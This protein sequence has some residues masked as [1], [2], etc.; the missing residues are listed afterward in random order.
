MLLRRSTPKAG[1]TK[2]SEEE[3]QQ[4]PHK[5]RIILRNAKS[6]AEYKEDLKQEAAESVSD[7]LLMA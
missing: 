5:V 3:E 2:G 4:N 6:S 1:M 7:S